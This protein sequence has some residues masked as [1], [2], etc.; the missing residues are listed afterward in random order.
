MT[1]EKM[2]IQRQLYSCI[3]LTVEKKLKLPKTVLPQGLTT[4]ISFLH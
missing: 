2:E 1:E 4:N 3:F